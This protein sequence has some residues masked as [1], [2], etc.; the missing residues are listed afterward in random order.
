MKQ[1][2]GLAVVVAAIIALIVAVIVGVIVGVA[3]SDASAAS[4]RTIGP[5]PFTLP[6]NACTPGAFVRKTQADICDGHTERP[7]L[8]TSERRA[9]LARYGVPGWTGANGE[10]DHRIPLFLGGTTDRRN[11]WPE[12][13]SIPNPK[14][15]LEGLVFRRVCA[16]TMRVRTALLIFEGNWRASYSYFVLRTGPLP[17]IL[18][19]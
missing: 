19:A 14:D 16:G 6:D 11:V 4:C 7:N 1:A 13:G 3:V 8:P 18:K 10:L 9:L 15:K 12:R 17:A 5:V 2:K